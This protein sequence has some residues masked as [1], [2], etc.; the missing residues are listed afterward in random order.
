MPADPEIWILRHGEAQPASEPGGDAGRRLTAAGERA[1]EALG[2]SLAARGLRAARVVTSPLA[3]ARRTAALAAGAG[4]A[5]AVP[6]EE[7][8][9]LA[10]GGNSR[11]LAGEV[12][13]DGRLPALL[14]GHNPDLEDLVFA[15]TGATV[16]L[17]K[18]A[19]VRIA[20]AAG[21]GRIIE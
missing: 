21:K 17:G 18:G 20:F 8:R 5:P 7:D 15:L 14:V 19:F 16:P 1:A 9:R 12:L 13:G 6:V 11:D 2:R 10:P 4:L 3:R